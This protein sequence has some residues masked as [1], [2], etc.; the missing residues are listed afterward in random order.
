MRI[1]FRLCIA[2]LCFY[3]VFLGGIER[4][5]FPCDQQ[6]EEILCTASAALIHY[7]ALCTMAWMCVEALHMYML[8]VRATGARIPKFFLLARLFAWGKCLFFFFL[9]LNIVLILRSVVS[10]GGKILYPFVPK[11]LIVLTKSP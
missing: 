10:K 3:A 11:S 9:Y 6:L 4:K 1:Q 2:F 8:F 5:Q 7:F